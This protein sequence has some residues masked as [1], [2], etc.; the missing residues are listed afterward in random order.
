MSNKIKKRKFNVNKLN[1]LE[2]VFSQFDQVK[3]AFLFGSHARKEANKLSDLDVGI[4]LDENFDKMIKIDI[5]TELT[6][7]N[8]FD[9]DLVII[10]N[11]DL[12][13]AFEIVKHNKI[14][15]KRSS[16]NV[17]SFFSLIIRKYLDFKP[18]LVIQ[19]NYLKERILNG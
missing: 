1:E 11:A 16:F 10:N 6:R 19:R 2:K 13:T 9:I 4:L 7:L 8:F 5:L 18:Y 12:L 15:Y 3:C 14:L 17:A